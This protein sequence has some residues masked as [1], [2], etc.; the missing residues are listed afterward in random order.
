[1]LAALRPRFRGEVWDW[2]KRHLSLSSRVTRHPGPIDWSWSPYLIGEW[3]PLWAYKRYE[4][5]GMIAG[6]QTGKTL[7]LQTTIAYDADCDPGPGLIVYPDQVTAERRSKGHI[8]PMLQDSMPHLMPDSPRDMG[9]LQYKL[10]TSDWYIG[11]AGSPSVLA[12]LPIKHLKLDETAKFT[13]SSS[14]EADPV[15][16]AEERITSY[17]PF[18]TVFSVTTPSE[19]GLP[20]WADWKDSTQCQYEIECPQC[21]AWQVMYFSADID[22]KWF[23]GTGGEWRGGIKWDHAEGLTRSQ[24]LASSYYQCE[25]CDRHISSAEKNRIVAAGRWKPGSPEAE[26]YRCHLP[27]WYAVSVSFAHVV[28]KWWDSYK[29]DDGR[30][31]FLNAVCAVPWEPEGREV[32]AEALKAHIAPGHRSG[33]IPVG[34]ACLMLTVDVHDDHLRYRIRAWAPDLTTWGV[35][36]GRTLPDIGQID[37]LLARTYQM[38][39]G[40]VVGIHGGIVDA[41]WRT[42]EVYQ[43]CLRNSGRLF[44]VMGQGLAHELFKPVKTWVPA[45]PSKGLMLSGWVLRID[46]NDARWKD[47]LFAR[48]DHP[49][50]KP[51]AWLVEEDVDDTYWWELQGEIKTTRQKEGKQPETLWILRHDNHCLDVEKYQ[52][53]AAE[54]WQVSTMFGVTQPEELPANEAEII[55]PYTGRPV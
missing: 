23:C 32:T 2:G 10:T 15:R 35:E 17:R 18:A 39:D 50:D 34:T 42:D 21:G 27:Q 55:N 5:S 13:T 28:A 33:M 1:M 44:P 37:K 49:T 20:G 47:R 6:A 4:N 24:R 30:R 40:G 22:R 8:R 43:V 14:T 29:S 38:P 52:L 46:I 12:S 48:F 54:L 51:G 11:W 16:N 26:R 19:P 45:D 41:R 53:L 31:R 25:A 3:S 36:T 7:A 9:I